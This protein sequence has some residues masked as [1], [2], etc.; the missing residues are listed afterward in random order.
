ML[1]T[2]VHSLR[3]ATS[4]EEGNESAEQF[5][6]IKYLLVPCEPFG[7]YLAA[8][9]RLGVIQAEKRS[10]AGRVGGRRRHVHINDVY[11]HVFLIRKQPHF[12][13]GLVYTQ[14]ADGHHWHFNSEAPA[15]LRSA[16]RA[17]GG[18][19]E[20]APYSSLATRACREL[21]LCRASTVYFSP[22]AAPDAPRRGQ[23]ALF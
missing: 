4:S 12:P 11:C 17:A 18:T 5:I 19:A 2:A 22:S 16:H 23:H 10:S 6:M 15:A 7:M 3:C 14:G 9:L 13:P 8:L 20:R 21:F 1:V